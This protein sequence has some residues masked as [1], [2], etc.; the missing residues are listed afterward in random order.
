MPSRFLPEFTATGY[1]EF[2]RVFAMAN[3]DSLTPGSDSSLLALRHAVQP[4]LEYEYIPYSDQ[5]RY[6]YFDELDR[7]RPRNELRYSLTNVFT[8]KR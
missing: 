8:A 5:D 1:T 2:S 6:P 3:E 4:R 7:I